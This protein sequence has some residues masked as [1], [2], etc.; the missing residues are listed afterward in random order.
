MGRLTA[1]SVNGK[2]WAQIS[3]NGE[4]RIQEIQYDDGHF[5]AFA[6][7]E[8][9]NVVE[10]RNPTGVVTREYDENKRLVSEGQPGGVVKFGY[11]A[12]GLLSSLTTPKG[13]TLGFSYDADARLV[14]VADWKGG[15]H[16]FSYETTRRSIKHRLPNQVTTDT[17]LTERGFPAEIITKLPGLQSLSLKYERNSNDQVT[18]AADSEAGLKKFSYSPDGFVLRVEDSSGPIETFSYDANGNRIGVNSEDAYFDPLNQMSRQGMHTM[19]YD[20]RGNLTMVSASDGE[21]RYKYNGQNLLVEVELPDGRRVEYAYDAFG[22]RISKK[23]GGVETVYVWAGNQLIAESVRGSKLEQRDY[24]FLPNSYTPLSFRVNGKIYQY[25]TDQRGMPRW[26]TDEAGE[27]V[28]SAVASTFGETSVLKQN[29]KQNIRFAGQYLDEETDLHYNRARYYSPRLGRYLSRDPL[30]I[31]AGLNFYLYAGN[32]PINNADPLGLIGFWQGMLA[33]AAVV[34]GVAILVVAAP[35]VAAAVVAVAAGGAIAA[36]TIGAA[37]AVVGGAALLG[38]GIGLA[39]ASE[40]ASPGDQAL[41]ALRGAMYGAGAALTVMGA[42]F[43]AAG[44][45]AGCGGG[46]LAAAGAGGGTFVLTNT[47]ANAI[48]AGA[49]SAVAGHMMMAAAGTGTG[50]SGATPKNKDNVKY[51]DKSDKHVADHGHADDGQPKTV[52]KTATKNA[53]KTQYKSKFGSSE[54][55]QKFTDEVVDHPGTT[56]TTQSNGRIRYTN[57]DLG[58]TTGTGQDGTPVKG[59]EV[60]VE[61]PSPKPGSNTGD[62]VTQYPAGKQGP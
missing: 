22:R 21:T 40:D 43:G 6:Y 32:D 49:A 44:L 36:G 11:D 10:A 27:L 58:R 15:V 38:G 35:V 8:A 4:G 13:E 9:G 57:D 17:L 53:G 31:V 41:A 5:V 14:R 7:D 51:T 54:G 33:G 16:K 48:G 26:V 61:G 29:V 52:D 62:V 3:Y 12:T 56:K 47:A 37:A 42:A 1:G 30:E 45:V 28:W 18:S 2:L 34:A 20:S 39:L 24:L 55:G 60:I 59:G 25:H 19:R 50:G 46:G 23:V